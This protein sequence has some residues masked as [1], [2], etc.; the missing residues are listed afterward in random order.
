MGYSQGQT[1]QGDSRRQA[2][3]RIA[4][5]AIVTADLLESDLRNIKADDVLAA[6]KVAAGAIADLSQK[7]LHPDSGRIGRQ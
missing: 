5:T 3:R 1:A 2:G 6:W 4:Y 7:Q